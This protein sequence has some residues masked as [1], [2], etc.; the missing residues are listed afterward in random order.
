M[1]LTPPNVAQTLDQ[2]EAKAIPQSDV[3]I[4]TLKRVFGDHT[5]FLDKEGLNI[6]EPVDGASDG[7]M[8]LV[9]VLQFA[10]WSDRK[11]SALTPHTPEDTDTVVLLSKAA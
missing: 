2:I 1:K 3:A 8:D 11:R 9:R 6:V 4:E 5:F 7:R 10:K